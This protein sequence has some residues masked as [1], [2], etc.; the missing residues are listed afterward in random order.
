MK[1]HENLA[2]GAKTFQARNKL[3]GN[4]YHKFG[5]VMFALM[6]HDYAPLDEDDW[7]R[8]GVI[9]MIVSKLIRYTENL[10][11]GGHLDSAHDL[12][13]YGA[14]LEELTEEKVERPVI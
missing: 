10:E 7:N 2:T 4:S 9:N 8:L 14:M 3:Y 13:V 5:N 11:K 12:M 1:A 6:P